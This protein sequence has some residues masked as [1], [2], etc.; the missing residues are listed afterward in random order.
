MEGHHSYNHPRQQNPG[1]SPPGES[2]KDEMSK[3]YGHVVQSRAIQKS[4]ALPRSSSRSKSRGK[5]RGGDSTAGSRISRSNSRGRMQTPQNN[6]INNSQNSFSVESKKESLKR[7]SSLGMIRD[8]KIDEHGRCR[9]HPNIELCKRDSTNS[10]APWRILL[11]DCPLCS[12][13]NNG[14]NSNNEML[15]RRESNNVLS[16]ELTAQTGETATTSPSSGD[17]T[18]DDSDRSSN[19]N[20]G[21]IIR[22]SSATSRQAPPPQRKQS[23]VQTLK[24]LG[25]MHTMEGDGDTASISARSMASRRSRHPPPP[26]PVGRSPHTNSSNRNNTGLN[27][28]MSSLSTKELSRMRKQR[29]SSE[30]INERIS[31]R[32]KQQHAENDEIAQNQSLERLRAERLAARDRLIGQRT[33]S[34]T[35]SNSVRKQSEREE[36]SG[37]FTIPMNDVGRGRAAALDD[38]ILGAAAEIRARAR[39]SLS[40]SRERR[41]AS[42]DIFGTA[43][44]LGDEHTVDGDT[45]SVASKGR[46]SI[47][48]PHGL[49]EPP[50]PLPVQRRSQSRERRSRRGDSGEIN[51]EGLDRHR[52]DANYERSSEVLINRRREMR[53][54]LAERQNAADHRRVSSG[55]DVGGDRDYQSVRDE[56]MDDWT[57]DTRRSGRSKERNERGRGRSRSRVRDGLSKIRSASLNAF[58]KKDNKRAESEDR[59]VDSGRM[60]FRSLVSKG[61]RLRSRSRGRVKS[62][63]GWDTTSAFDMQRSVSEDFDSLSMSKSDIGT[64]REGRRGSGSILGRLSNSQHSR[65]EDDFD[66]LRGLG[67]DNNAHV[68]SERS[69]AF[70]V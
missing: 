22:P 42:D 24:A 21:V 20:D 51:G 50:K 60:S 28:S 59:S 26:P 16:G 9:N 12:L 54:R 1:R 6:H 47:M 35:R 4:N 44:T 57:M 39:R 30:G 3:K 34:S 33:T 18:S 45:V 2:E 61:S 48:N 66:N 10:N 38:D 43:S 46:R 8:G 65:L 29:Y 62:V 67:N 31:D 68:R 19:N 70:E 53:Q 69:G 27:T 52:F 11:Q 37:T 23:S 56:A 25:K 64:S 41:K 32:R 5:S 7:C 55:A 17:E 13:N 58:R 49:A 15:L 63:D 14:N 36:S 40:R